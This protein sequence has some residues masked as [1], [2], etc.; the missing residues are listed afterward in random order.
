[1]ATVG[2]KR[3]IINNVTV[4]VK[5]NTA[6]YKPSGSAK[7]PILDD[8]SGSVMA[9]TQENSAGMIKLQLSTL[10]SADT[11]KYRNLEDAEIVIEL[12]DG[13][14]VVGSLMTQTA[15]NPITAA[16]GVVEYEFMGNV[17]VN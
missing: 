15:D 2:I 1:M 16:D 12:L 6:E 5:S 9:F 10:K 8:G 7:T 17:K 4:Q 13:K 11:D 14:N 3:A